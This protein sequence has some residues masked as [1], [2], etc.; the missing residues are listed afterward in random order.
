MSAE[1]KGN[2]D[3]MIVERLFARGFVVVGGIFWVSAVFG[4]GYGYENL[5]PLVSARNALMPLALTVI[6][7]VVGWFWE[8][9][10]AAVLVAGAAA[11]TVWGVFSNWE[12]GVWSL[13]IA[14]L[15]AP[16]AIAALLFWFASRMQDVIAKEASGEPDGEART[17]AEGGTLHAARS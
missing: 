6:I 11:V 16:M 8:K 1:R 7:L 17:N 4:A 10:A 15:I 2:A 3:R 14:T 13:V 9:I 12:P 5:T